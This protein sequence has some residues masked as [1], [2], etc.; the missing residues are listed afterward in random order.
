MKLK[1]SNLAFLDNI[2]RI[3]FHKF[4]MVKYTLK[5][6][7]LKNNHRI[8]TMKS[9]GQFG[10]RRNRTRQ[11]ATSKIST[12]QDIARAVNISQ[13]MANIARNFFSP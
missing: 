2:S 6:I 5:E 4:V 13:E 11:I 1:N 9:N 12:V 8:S 10:I 7:E 3:M